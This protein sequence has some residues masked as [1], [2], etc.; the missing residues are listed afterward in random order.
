MTSRSGD[1]HILDVVPQFPMLF[2]VDDNGYLAAFLIGDKLDSAHVFIV[3][4][5]VTCAFSCSARGGRALGTPSPAVANDTL[6]VFVWYL[7]S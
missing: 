4:Q 2:Q 7:L 6:A 1:K 5:T 3:L